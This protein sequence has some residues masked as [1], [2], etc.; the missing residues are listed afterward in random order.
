MYKAR[1][2]VLAIAI[3]VT[4]V[5][6]PA[7]RSIPAA[8]AQYESYAGHWTFYAYFS[9]DRNP[10]NTQLCFLLLFGLHS[11]ELA[12]DANVD[13]SGHFTYTET[14]QATNN[15]PG[16]PPAC[17]PAIFAIPWN[18]FCNGT[19][20]GDG[21]LRPGY[22]GP[23]GPPDFYQT[24][25]IGTFQG[26]PPIHVVNPLPPN[27]Y[28]FDTGIAALP[29]VFDTA[30]YLR[31]VQFLGPGQPAPPGVTVLVVTKHQ[32]IGVPLVAPPG[33]GISR[34]FMVFWNSKAPGQGQV[35]FGSGPG[36]TGLVNVATS[37]LF[38]GTT[39]HGFVVMG[40]E[41]AGSSGDNGIQPGATYWYERVTVTSS[42]VEVDNNGGKCYS[43]TIPG[44]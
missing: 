4:M 8:H 33:Q 29:G 5:F 36:C 40:D 41:L 9:C 30:A 26:N 25:E 13:A 22:P 31:L 32:P 6:V 42:G 37:D 17:T 2:L 27:L 1:R 44:L 14:F 23:N 16:A 43:V 10:Q 38:A 34:D 19:E 11:Y 24:S 21:I 20:T 7:M 15:V 3:A 18:G 12:F 28:P 35:Y 39:E